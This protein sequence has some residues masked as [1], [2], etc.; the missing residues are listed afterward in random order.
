METYQEKSGSTYA[1][2]RKQWFV[3]D[4]GMAATAH[5]AQG[6]QFKGVLVYQQYQWKPPTPQQNERG[7][8]LCLT[9]K[10]IAAGCILR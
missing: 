6:S 8:S 5:K 7:I 9:Q 10:N 2:P 3:V 1:F 4:Y